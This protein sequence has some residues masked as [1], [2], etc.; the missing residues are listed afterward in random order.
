M[1]TTNKEL[2]YYIRKAFATEWGGHCVPTWTVV[3]VTRYKEYHIAKYGEDAWYHNDGWCE[4]RK[5]NE[6]IAD[7]ATH[8][9]RAITGTPWELC[10]GVDLYFDLSGDLPICVSEID[11][12]AYQGAPYEECVEW[13]GELAEPIDA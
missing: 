11:S 4:D 2:G 10:D 13:L 6:E 1:G 9:V 3:D 12:P 8:V 5:Y 7:G